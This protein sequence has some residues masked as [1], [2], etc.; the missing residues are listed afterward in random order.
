MRPRV[1]LIGPRRRRQGLG[2]FVARDLEAAGATVAGF[3]ST[4]DE[5]RRAA[6]EQLRDLAGIAPRGY[7][8]L[9]DMLAAESLHALA[10]LSPTG[11]HERWLL[12][13][14][15]AGLHVLCEKPLVWGGAALL[16]RT[17]TVCDA[18]RSRGLLLEENCQ[19]PFTLD[20]FRALHPDTPAGPPARF[21]MRLAPDSSGLDALGD[22][23]PHPLSLLQALAP[24]KRPQVESPRIRSRD[25]SVDVQF[26]YVAD[27]ARVEVDLALRQQATT[28]RPASLEIDGRGRRGG[29]LGRGR[30]AGAAL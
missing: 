27:D 24:A 10:I 29:R 18:F 23:L 1:G 11:T 25:G 14:A 8:R 19:W 16:E 28:P 3:L 13:A 2:P 7:L 6:E 9:E 4:R 26:A 12:A 22:C 15:D 21:A 5:T 20:A 17:R 30:T